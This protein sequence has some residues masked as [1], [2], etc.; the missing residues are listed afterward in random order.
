MN[1]PYFNSIASAYVLSTLSGVCKDHFKPHKGVLPIITSIMRYFLYYHR[2]RFSHDPT[3]LSTY[4]GDEDYEKIQE[5]IPTK[6]TWVQ[7]VIYG[8][9][10]IPAYWYRRQPRK[11]DKEKIRKVGYLAIDKYGGS[12]GIKYEYLTNVSNKSKDDW[13]SFIQD[14]NEE[15]E[16]KPNSNGFTKVVQLLQEAVESYVYAVLGAQA[17]TR[18][19]IVDAEAKSLQ[20]QHI[21]HTI[22][23]DTVAQDD[24]SVFISNM[25][26]AISSTNVTLDMTL[27][28]GIALIPSKMIILNKPVPGYNN[29]L[30][31]ATKTMNFGQNEKINFQGVTSKPFSHTITQEVQ[32]D[33]DE[34]SDTSDERT[35]TT[36]ETLKPSQVSEEKKGR[37]KGKCY[38]PFPFPKVFTPP[39]KDTHWED[40]TST[41]LVTL[42]SIL[43]PYMLF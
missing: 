33:T 32:E 40:L 36:E 6:G 23:T 1:D 28:P 15:R 20:T 24:D 13:M 31:T 2:A 12:N 5:R 42:G 22:V 19:K 37:K 43:N 7:R 38:Q 21:F 11:L 35:L 27:I 14:K 16:P 41:L 3:R 26:T 9:K 17:R 8:S 39:R 10:E 4:L 34:E 29:V 25:G 18:F 30:T